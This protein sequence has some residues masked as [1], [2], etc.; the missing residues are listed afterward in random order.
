[1]RIEVLEYFLEIADCKS[2]SRASENLFISQQGLSKSMRALEGE[3]GVTLFQKSGRGIELTAVSY[4]HLD[5]Y[6]RQIHGCR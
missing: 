3:L 2:F 6:K 1:M 5:V 4:T